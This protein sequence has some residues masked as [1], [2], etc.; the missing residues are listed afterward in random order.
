[1]KKSYTN[2]CIIC[3]FICAVSVSAQKQCNLMLSAYLKPIKFLPAVSWALE[4]GAYY[5]LVQQNSY[6]GIRVFSA[7]GIQ[8]SQNHS[9]Y[10]DG[11]IKICRKN[12]TVYYNPD[13]PK[14]CDEEGDSLQTESTGYSPR[15]ISLVGLR[16]TSYLYDNGFHQIEAGLI[17]PSAGDYFLYDE[18]IIGLSY[19]G[20]FNSLK[21]IANGGTVTNH[22]AR[23]GKWGSSLC[24]NNAF[25]ERFWDEHLGNKLLETN[26]AGITLKW[27]PGN[28]TED[29]EE[30]EGD[31]F[32][33]FQEFS[34]DV[35]N[36][37]SSKSRIVKEAG[38]ILYSEFGSKFRYPQFYTGLFSELD[39]PLE[40]KLRIQAVAQFENS[41]VSAGGL[42]QL[43][44]IQNWDRMGSSNFDI[45][46]MLS[47]SQSSKLE[48][49]PSYSNYYQGL[50]FLM[51]WRDT[52][53]YF[54]KFKHTFPAKIKP[55]VDIRWTQQIRQD[56][57]R[58]LDIQAGILIRKR[59]KINM[60]Y[61]L[62]NSDR[63]KK[64]VNI[65]KVGIRIGI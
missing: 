19:S 34:D 42:L 54:T 27:L 48:F 15:G 44:K 3:L 58:E 45:G 62:V 35:K 20:M 61:G 7:L 37:N 8:I 1:M 31:E 32:E 50:F 30:N 57:M 41:K 55:Y 40:M 46:T 5:A 21:L 22:F 63:L 18:R 14:E 16:E 43:S 11:G 49:S 56:R 33:E 6:I 38:I 12:E 4:P 24:L 10:F 51:D 23:M 36:S 65:F 53:L 60:I 52:P 2:I 13:T 59:V 9:L 17:T 28:K 47:F 29:E 26:F 25:R 39:L 64:S